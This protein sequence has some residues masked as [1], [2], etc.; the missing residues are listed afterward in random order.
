[1]PSCANAWEKP[2][3]SERATGSLSIAWWTAHRPSTNRSSRRSGRSADRQVAQSLLQ[4]APLGF[5]PRQ[6]ERPFVRPARVLDPSKTT[7]Q[8]G[9][10]RMREVILLEVAASE[11]RIDKREACR[12]TIVHGDRRSAIQLDDR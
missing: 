7:A 8:I 10:G 3:S 4:K 5:L 6:G 2:H 12:R 1:M 9:A 11:D